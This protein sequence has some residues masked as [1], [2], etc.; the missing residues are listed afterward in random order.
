MK[1]VLSVCVSVAAAL[2]AGACSGGSTPVTVTPP[3]NIFSNSNLQ[4]QYAFSMTGTTVDQTTGIGVPF[5]RT[6]SFIA[7]G[8]GAITGG[9]EDVNLIFANG[10]AGELAFT[11]GSYTIN[12]DGR[13]T[14]SLIDSTGTLTFSITLT[15]STNGYL[16][17]MPTDFQSAG[18]GSF[19]KQNASS[20]QVSGLSGNYAFDIS[21]VDANGT[22]ESVVGQLV[23]NSAGTFSGFA[24]DNDG[25]TVNG[26]VAGAATIAGTYGIDGTQPGDLANFGRGVF[27][28]GGIK[29]VFYIVGPNQVKLMETTSGGTLSGDAF[30]QSNIP[31]TAAGI[32]GGF[33]YA[34]GGSGSGAPFTR[35]G[36]FSASGGALSSVIVDNN[37]AG[38]PLSLGPVNGAYTIDSSGNGRGTITFN[39]PG[40]T[41]AFTYVFYLISPTQAFVQDQSL[42]V[43]EDGSMLAQGSGTISNSSLAGSY[44]INW[45]GV[46][47]T[48]AGTGEEDLVGATTVSGG[49]LSGTVDINDF[50]PGGQATGIVLT[51]TLT[52]G[53]D[54]TGRNAL[55]V[56]LATPAASPITAFAYVAANNNIL[57]VSTQKNVRVM[58]GVLTPQAP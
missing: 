39:V 47:S 49:A 19:V 29:G 12:G 9:T 42:N 26:G 51:G 8:K 21:G 32:S 48:S 54:P 57:F 28:I 33:V 46:T 24:D 5:T 44:A 25:A 56:N 30:L 35:G 52:L 34:M 11:G 3:P 45:S 58:V 10:G 4:G 17:D 22:P 27:S 41:D 37:N 14:L 20:F 31:T 53:A 16:V 50:G 15:S 13:G 1:R 38:Q 2:W 43:V 36:K 7:D 18:N 6:G 23:S 55:T 40:F